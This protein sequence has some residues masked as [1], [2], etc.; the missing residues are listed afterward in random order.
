MSEAQQTLEAFEPATD[1]VS[2]TRTVKLPLQT[3]QRKNELVRIGIDAYQSVL[4]Y[5]ADRLPNYPEHEWVPRHSHMYHQAKRGLPDFPDDISGRGFKGSLVQQAQNQVSES[6][7]SWR[8]QGKP[9][10]SP[11]GDFGQGD[12]LLIRSDEIEIVANDSGYGLKTG[13]ISYNPVW[14][15][16]ITGDYQQ[17]FL[18]RVVDDTDTASAGEAELRLTDDGQLFAY[19]SVSW[20][21]ETYAVSDIATTIGVDLNDDPLAV[22]AVW[23]D[24]QKSVDDVLFYSGSEFRHY[25]EQMKRQKSKAM[26]DDNLKAVVESR[27]D[28]RKYTN[29]VTNVVSRRVVDLATEHTPCQIQLEDLTHLRETVE[30]PI[31][32]WPYAEIQEKIISKAQEKGVPVTLI[33][34]RNTSIECR[35]CGEVNPA[36]RSG[37]EFECWECGYEVHADLNAAV[38]IAQRV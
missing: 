17:E 12:Y 31:H 18:E 13:F 32:D 35:K 26:Q 34:P 20:E 33:D 8:Q 28:Y 22:A 23:N 10:E 6:F 11:K 4:S 9:G 21:V 19:L 30:N 7:K 27:R 36:M 16:I 24:T 38:N 5:M 15:R 2:I 3:S 29:H 25:R 1:S 14:F 37:R